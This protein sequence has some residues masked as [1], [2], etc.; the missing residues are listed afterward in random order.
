MRNPRWLPTLV[1]ATAIAVVLVLP[2]AATADVFGPLGSSTPSAPSITTDKADYA[3][4]SPVTLT[5]GGWQPGERV[6]IV[7]NDDGLQEPVWQHT[8]SVRAN[9]TGGFTYD[10]DL[11]I[12]LVAN[13]TV[14]ATGPLSGTAH[15]AFTDA[16][17]ERGCGPVPA[18]TL[19]VDTTNDDFDTEGEA[20]D[21]SLREAISASNENAGVQFISVPPGTYTLT[22]P[23]AGASPEDNEEGDLDV[24]ESV[25]IIKGA[26]AGSVI[27]QAGASADRI[28]HVLLS[29]TAFALSDLT[30]QNGFGSNT[31]GGGI[32]VE[33]GAQA[34]PNAL[35]LDN[36]VVRNNTARE[37]QRRCWH[38]HRGLLRRHDDSGFGHRREPHRRELH[39]L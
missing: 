17:I 20:G 7:V 24:R 21:C 4:N 18:V 22:R 33:G 13:Y 36:I 6:H 15:A 3:P 5:G 28:F 2:Q 16:G 35:D 1:S 27:I 10:F 31:A 29:G 12:W 34:A 25:S 38:L 30:V 11:P 8:G 9:L 19:F 39:R 32:R 14:T 26:G 37:R 23:K